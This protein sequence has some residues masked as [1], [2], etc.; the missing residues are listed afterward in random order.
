MDLPGSGY[1]NPIDHTEV[2]LWGPPPPVGP[3]GSSLLTF[4]ERFIV[5][6]VTTLSTRLGQPGLVESRLAAVIGGSLGGNLALRL[7]RRPEP[8]LRNAVAWSPGSVWRASGTA[9]TPA[10][11]VDLNALLAG[12]ALAIPRAGET[13]GGASRDAFF[14]GAF[15]QAIPSK[16]QPEQWYRDDFPAKQQYI[17]NARLD[18][19]ET[20]TRQFR[21]WHW[22]VS[23]EELAWSWQDP[24]VQDFRSRVLLGAGAA[25]EITP[26]RIFS[27]TQKVAAQLATTNGD[28]FFVDRTGHSF[29]AERP[30]ALARIIRVFLADQPDMTWSNMHTPP[31]VSLT[32]LLSA[33]TV[34]N[35]PTST[36]RPHV[37]MVGGDGN[38]WCRWSDDNG[39]WNWLNMYRPDG[40]NLTGSAAAVTVM[41][42][43]TSL[44]R[45]HVFIQGA[46]GNLWCRWSDG[47]GAWNWLNMYQPSDV[48]L[49][50]VLA[51]VTVMNTPTSLQRAHVF[52]LGSDGNLWCRWSDGNGAWNWLN[53]YRPSGVNLIGLAAA[54]TVMTTPTSLQRP[55]VFLLGT[56]GNLWC[57]WADDNGAWNWLNM[58]KPP[59]VSLAQL[60]GAVTVMNTPTSLQRAHV[61][62]RGTDGEPVVPLGRRQRRLELAEY[63]PAGRGEPDRVGCR[64][65]SDEHP[66]LAATDS[67]LHPGQRRESVVQAVGRC[68]GVELGEYS[69]TSR[70]EPRGITTCVD[71]E[72]HSDGAAATTPLPR[73]ERPQPVGR[74]SRLSRRLGTYSPL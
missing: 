39:A 10:A 38:L 69:Q 55:H 64:R 29:H 66:H 60:L 13:E 48:G 44:Q 16:T 45:T 67:P 53:M 33:V 40:V 47:N 34:M 12:I 51:A 32:G 61:F 20:Y 15:D 8:W 37:F 11:A 30:E 35:T 73:R 18:R 52:L 50:S 23:V 7:A 27:N 68:R 54:V 28:T 26:A 1:V 41:N 71:S 49:A 65:D 2:G 31:G 9:A 25:D 21:R 56:D 14:A 74:H 42:T 3:V 24:A 5:R 62:L 70:R 43:P 17:T 6:F 59:D 58:Y 22:R 4:L 36:Q 19:R 72:E 57:R 63:V 46:D